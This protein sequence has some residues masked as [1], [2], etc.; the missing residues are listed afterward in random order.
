MKKYINRTLPLFLLSAAATA[1][2]VTLVQDGAAFTNG[3]A[4]GSVFVVRGT[5]L[6]PAGFVAAN[7]PAYPTTLNNVKVTLT[8]VDGGAVVTALMAHA[9]N[10]GGVNQLAAV[11]PSDAAVGLYD[12]RVQNGT[13]TSPAFRTSVVARKPGIVTASSDGTGPAQ[14][15]L[16]GKLILQRT[17]N[18]GQLG[19]FTTRSAHPGERV[20]LWGTGLGADLASDTGGTSSDQTAVGVIRVLVNGAEV[21]PLYA[22][23]AQGFP[24]LDQIAFTLPAATATNCAVLIQVRAGVVFSNPVTIAT[25]ADDACPATETIRI[26]EVESNGGT[27]GDWVE[28]YNPGPAA[29]TLTG[30]GFKD[31]DDT[32][33]MY[34]LP[35]TVVPA[36]G[37]K[38]LD[39][40]DFGFGLGAADSARLFRPDGTLAD[41]YS[42]TAHANT[43]Y[44]RC[45]N[46]SGAL[47]ATTSSTRAA[48]ND[49]GIP[50]RINEV[51][52]NGGTPGD[53]V[54]LIN[55]GS[56]TLDLS[57]FAF[58]DN[59]DTHNYVLPTGSTLAP[60][61]Y[62][63][64]EEATFGFGLGAADSARLYDTTGVA[65][66]SYAWTAHA[67]NT[68]GRCPNGSGNF[69]DTSAS[70]KSASNLCEGQ[71]VTTYAAWPG[72]TAIQTADNTAVFGGNLSGL[73]YEGTG[74]SAVIWGAR[75]GPGAL[76]RLVPNGSLWVPDAAN[77][78]GT[79]KL[80]RYPDGT[81]DPDAEGVTFAGTGSGAG[82]FVSTERN[83]AANSLSKNAI[84]R[85]D[86][87]AAG[88]TLT[89]T[90]EWNLTAD[91]PVVGPNLGI[92]GITWIPDSF[93]VSKGFIDEA[94]GRAYNPADY[95]N[96]GTGIFFVGV[97][98]NGNI[99]GYALDQAGTN[100]TRIAT[101]STGY[102][103]VMDLAFDRELNDLW[104]VCDDT[105]QGR[106]A[107][108]RV[109]SG[110]FTVA[111]RFER[112]TGMPNLNNEG[113]TF[114]PV[115]Q[116]NGTTRPVFWADD[117]ETD[118]HAIRTGTL[119]CSV[120]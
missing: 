75:N 20:D 101:I 55:N 115:S 52:S 70:T 42:W 83:N 92:E 104:A 17:S 59:D 81:G 10:I 68:Y 61:A 35:T 90:H 25:S 49:C 89:A 69:G 64:L 98:A 29:V 4:P 111:R 23:R 79:A 116:C 30:W 84:L 48:A 74:S 119:N 82:L 94:K 78:W 41:S 86:P 56:A 93:L 26:N 5:G 72:G 96:H 67:A 73:A 80:L 62:L 32:H 14:A 7:A 87:A 47:T 71:V 108:L 103:G 120:P 15:T 107:V 28:L 50:V 99:Y 13:T 91:L 76:F 58:R 60:G 54:E 39:E 18:V 105:C 46:S 118:G 12:L 77:G 34:V 22:G 100:F 33:A 85:F 3:M 109:E 66:D 36:G 16:N 37:Y 6:S 27:P 65:V 110:K 112:P 95:A 1:Q 9:Y 40:A 8:A 38:M 43:T 57:G 97:E 114:A 88:T 117:A 11:L 113:F 44:G 106:S 102:T 31:N 21:T 2:T 24:G 63:M 51:E 19:E 45:P 53:W